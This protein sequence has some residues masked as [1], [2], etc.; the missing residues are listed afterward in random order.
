VREC[1][2]VTA[3]E[4]RIR[5][6][7]VVSAARPQHMIHFGLAVLSADSATACCLCSRPN[8]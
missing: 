1:P 7:L 8:V 3:R 6:G 4:I 2:P 5:A